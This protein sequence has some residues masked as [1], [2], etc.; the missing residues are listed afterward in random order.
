MGWEI[1]QEQKRKVPGEDNY[2]IKKAGKLWVHMGLGFST[3]A[4]V[5]AFQCN[6]FFTARFYFRIWLYPGNTPRKNLFCVFRSV[7]GASTSDRNSCCV[8]SRWFW[9][10]SVTS[11]LLKLME[12]MVKWSGFFYNLIT[13][14]ATVLNSAWK[15]Y[16]EYFLV[17]VLR[18]WLL[19]C[20]G[21]R[22]QWKRCGVPSWKTWRNK[23]NFE[24]NGI[25]K[26]GCLSFPS[27][28]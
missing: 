22:C 10:C 4:T 18:L 2:R 28:F 16:K 9:K 13:F 27:D 8:C 7:H 11:W 21:K 20:S 23:Q 14:L 12:K 25:P 24:E 6:S 15:C 19:W 17:T 3:I 5:S 26:W 1:K